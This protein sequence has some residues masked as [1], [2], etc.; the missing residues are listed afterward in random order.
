[1]WR[2]KHQAL[3]EERAAIVARRAQFEAARAQWLADHEAE[4]AAAE[5]EHRQ[6]ARAAERVRLLD[7]LPIFRR[8]QHSIAATLARPLRSL[9]ERLRESVMGV[10]DCVE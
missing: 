8:A 4:C 1:M 5:A 7:E 10:L 2:R 3:D 6:L 9:L